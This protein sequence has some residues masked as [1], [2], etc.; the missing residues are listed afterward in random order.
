MDEPFDEMMGPPP[1]RRNNNSNGSNSKD[2]G[3]SSSP[4]LSRSLLSTSVSGAPP[5]SAAFHQNIPDRWAQYEEDSAALQQESARASARAIERLA[6]RDP[7]RKPLFED[8]DDLEEN[9]HTWTTGRQR[10]PYR[11]EPDEF[12]EDEIQR[13]LD[14][15]FLNRQHQRH[16]SSHLPP[17]SNHSQVPSRHVRSSSFEDVTFEEEEADH[18]RAP[19]DVRAE[20]L[21][22]LELAEMAEERFSSSRQTASSSPMSSGFSFKSKRSPAALSGVDWSSAPRRS[23][24]AASMSNKSMTTQ[25]VHDLLDVDRIETRAASSRPAAED[26]LDD[27]DENMDTTASTTS[28]SNAKSWSSRYSVDHTLLALTGGKFSASSLLDDMDKEQDRIVKSARNMFATSPHDLKA[29]A[30]PASPPR[31]LRGFSFKQQKPPPPIDFNLQSHRTV[32]T[33]LDVNGLSL[34]PVPSRLSW[35]EQLERKKKRRRRCLRITLMVTILII[36]MSVLLGVRNRWA[37]DVSSALDNQVTDQPL[38]FYVTSNVPYTSNANVLVFRDE[39]LTLSSNSTPFVVHLGNIQN[40]A[41]TLCPPVTY[42]AARSLLLTSPVPILMLPGEHD[43][44]DCPFP[45]QSWQTWQRFFSQF[46]DN[47]SHNFTIQ[48]PESRPEN[49]VM[50]QNNVLILGLHLVGGRID[51]AAEWSRRQADDAKFVMDQLSQN[52]NVRAVILLGNARPCPQTSEFFN[53]IKSTLQSLTM[54]IAY[55]HA[56]AGVDAVQQYTPFADV[57][58]LIAYQSPIGGESPLLHVTVGFGSMPIQ[59]A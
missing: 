31:G 59:V 51:D 21:K 56:N 49:F 42:L 9:D 39:L 44:N 43:W 26:Y 5:P 36:V 23:S 12:D 20:A 13:K 57:S 38:S 4:Q 8:D 18:V 16:K 10:K 40:S 11:D 53:A 32:W 28:S 30:N 17:L 52:G 46:E 41:V 1:I 25:N 55:I 50:V 6:H 47:Y 3:D 24:G 34:Q 54:P 14:E 15:E 48:R 58:N 45:S 35:Q 29:S 27:N 2:N 33:D 37:T 19:R 22:V 7:P